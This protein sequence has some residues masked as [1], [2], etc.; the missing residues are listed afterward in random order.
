MDWCFI[1]RGLFNFW[2]DR[3]SSSRWIPI[4]SC[5]SGDVNIT[6]LREFKRL[7]DSINVITDLC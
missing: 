6:I 7:G 3:V 1:C 2:P 4:R 5:S